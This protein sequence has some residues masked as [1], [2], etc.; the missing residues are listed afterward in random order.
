M[1]KGFTLIELIVVV[2]IILVLGGVV[3]SSLNTAREKGEKE[4]IRT[5][6]NLKG[7]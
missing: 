3:L 7:I 2:A 1:Q 5:Q 4:K 6:I